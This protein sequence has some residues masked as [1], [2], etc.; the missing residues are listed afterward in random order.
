MFSKFYKTVTLAK[1]VLYG[2]DAPYGINLVAFYILKTLV[3][4]FQSD[5]GFSTG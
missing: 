5:M 1:Q 4:I 2:N 3:N